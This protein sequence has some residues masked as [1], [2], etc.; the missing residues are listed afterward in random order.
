MKRPLWIALAAVLLLPLGAKSQTIDDIVAKNVQARGGLEKLRA[1][2][3]MRTTAKITEGD[4]RAGFVQENKRD[5]MVRKEMLLQGM[6]RIQAYDG[7][8]AWRLN[9]F[10]G[11]RDPE[12]ISQEE[13]KPL[14]VDADLEGPLVDYKQ[15]GHKAELIGHDSV[16]GTDCFKIKLTLKDG[17]VRYYY[18]DADSYLEIKIETQMTVRGAV[19]YRDIM[20]GDYDQVGG[21]YF[22]FLVQRGEHGSD[23]WTLFTVDKIELNVPL[24]DSRFSLPATKA[25]SKPPVASK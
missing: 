7:R 5:S 19:Q 23:E 14:V 25:E 11:R 24:E 9:P 22:P 21:V 15:K 6:V 1:I 4:F 3:S 2:K 12:L 17:D 13:S 20:L 16:E 10:G 8:V 18:L